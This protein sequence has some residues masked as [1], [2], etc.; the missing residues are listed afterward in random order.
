MQKIR[1]SIVGWDPRFYPRHSGEEDWVTVLKYYNA[2]D[3][4]PKKA[5]PNNKKADPFPPIIVIKA[6]A[7]PYTY[8]LLDGLHRLKAFIKAGIGFIYAE[9]ERL[10]ESKWLARATELNIIGKRV[11]TNMDI[12]SISVRLSKGGYTN[13]QIAKLVNLTPERLER[14]IIERVVKVKQVKGEQPIRN[15][16]NGGDTVILKAPFKHL[17]GT[18]KAEQLEKYQRKFNDLNAVH[19]LGAAADLLESDALDLADQNVIEVLDRLKEA[20]NVYEIA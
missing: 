6:V 12:A 5:N 11:L 10:P 3:A 20:L 9:V 17:S 7:K 15:K 14:I 2:L 8:L 1:I 18:V 16:W 4:E 13:K 19:I